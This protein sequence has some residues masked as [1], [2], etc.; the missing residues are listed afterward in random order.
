M[1]PLLVAVAAVGGWRLVFASPEPLSAAVEQVNAGQQGACA[2][3]ESA[4]SQSRAEHPEGVAAP[5]GYDEA[6]SRCIDQRIAAAAAATEPLA[7]EQRLLLVADPA[8][9][10]QPSGE[11]LDRIEEQVNALPGALLDGK[12]RIRLRSVE[13]VGQLATS[14][15]RQ[16]FK[17]HRVQ[18]RACHAKAQQAAPAL[19]GDYRVGVD[20]DAQGMVKKVYAKPGSAESEP[21][22]RCLATLLEGQQLGAGGR[23]TVELRMRSK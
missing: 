19:A 11:Q 6:M 1:A 7:R 22:Q 18:L 15:A 8:A 21:L 16:L 4:L 17:E 5:P 12:P 14:A 20:V 2:A 10:L 13:V 23:V 9:V 3:F